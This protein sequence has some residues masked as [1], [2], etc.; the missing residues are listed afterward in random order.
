MPMSQPKKIQI[1]W[2]WIICNESS[3]ARSYSSFRPPHFFV[4][5]LSLWSVFLCPHRGITIGKIVNVLITMSQWSTL[6]FLL[7]FFSIFLLHSANKSRTFSLCLMIY[8]QHHLEKSSIKEK[9]VV[10]SNRSRLGR[11]L[12]IRMNKIKN[13]LSVMNRG[14]KFHIGLLTDDAMLTKF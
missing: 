4:M 6:I 10:I 1:I 3:P 5:S 2:R 9:L 11:S 14:A 13:S 8:T 12:N 7:V